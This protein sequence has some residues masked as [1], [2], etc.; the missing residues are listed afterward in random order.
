MLSIP[1]QR[2][3]PDKAD[4]SEGCNPEALKLLN[5]LAVTDEEP[6]SDI[7]KGLE[8]LKEENKE[9]KPKQK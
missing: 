9:K 2:I 1:L 3:H 7:W 5:Q 4:G 8:A 6:R